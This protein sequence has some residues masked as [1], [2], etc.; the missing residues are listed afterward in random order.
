[1]LLMLAPQ[2]F[3]ASA[4]VVGPPSADPIEQAGIMN[5]A[6]AFTIA[7]D[8]QASIVRFRR[9]AG[10]AICNR[11]DYWGVNGAAPIP[12]H[13]EWNGRA[14]TVM[15]GRCLRINAPSALVAAAAPMSSDTIL[16]GT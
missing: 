11:V 16:Q 4:V 6:R 13:V 2:A 9:G 5:S 15:P 7:N 3:G 1:L 12:L 14:A 8:R 10:N